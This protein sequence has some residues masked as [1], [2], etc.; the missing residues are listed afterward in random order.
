MNFLLQFIALLVVAIS[1]CK[2][3]NGPQQRAQGEFT[4]NNGG[5]KQTIEISFSAQRSRSQQ[6]QPQ[7]NEFIDMIKRITM[8]TALPQTTRSI[9]L[10][11]RQVTPRVTM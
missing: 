11:T 4:I 7:T 3:C 2:A 1:I 8:P 10:R 9:R 6:G 5:S